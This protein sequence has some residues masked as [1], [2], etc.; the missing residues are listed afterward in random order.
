MRKLKNLIAA[1]SLTL[2]AGSLA[3]NNPSSTGR[4]TGESSTSS[5]IKNMIQI[6][7]EYRQQGFNETVKVHFLVD[8]SGKVSQVLAVCADP[9]LKKSVEQQFQQLNFAQF[10]EKTLYSVNINFKVI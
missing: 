4:L 10:S 2:F 1:L 8:K 6:P 7:A 9:V 5:L 3:A